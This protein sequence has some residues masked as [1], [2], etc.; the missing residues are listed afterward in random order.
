MLHIAYGFLI[1]AVLAD[2][3]S[4]ETGLWQS[5]IDEASKSGGGRVTVPA[6][7]HPVGQLYL[8]NNVELHLEEGASLE[9]VPGLHNYA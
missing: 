4:P 9:G 6:G 1:A 2:G 8:K 3:P 5:R 7:R